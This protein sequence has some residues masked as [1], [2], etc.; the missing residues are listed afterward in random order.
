MN[1][2]LKKQIKTNTMRSYEACYQFSIDRNCHTQYL[3]GDPPASPLVIRNPP[4]S[5][6]SRM[7][8]HLFCR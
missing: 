1:K 2:K 6:G 8:L 5:F 4:F 3:K 7:E